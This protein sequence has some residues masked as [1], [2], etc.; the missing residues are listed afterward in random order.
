MPC[1]LSGYSYNKHCVHCM[2]RKIKDL[3]A[4]AAPQMA[5]QKQ[6]ETFQWMGPLMAE[7]V[8]EVLRNEREQARG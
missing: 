1:E 3:R 7:Q 4:P 6:R 5:K 2:V 8:L